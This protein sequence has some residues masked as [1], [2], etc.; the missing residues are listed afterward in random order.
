MSFSDLEKPTTKEIFL[1]QFNIIS[2]P[3]PFPTP[4][5]KIFL[6]FKETMFY[7]LNFKSFSKK[8]R[9][10]NSRFTNNQILFVIEFT[11]FIF[12]IF[13]IFNQFFYFTIIINTSF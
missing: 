6:F 3:I 13:K 2:F 10:H 11:F 7:N 8:I 9:I 4:E 5:I 12:I 1:R